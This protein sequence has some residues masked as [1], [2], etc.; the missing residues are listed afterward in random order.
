[1]SFT[2]LFSLF[3]RMSLILIKCVNMYTYVYT[4][5][6]PICIFGA[7]CHLVEVVMVDDDQ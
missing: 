4:K 6:A 3:S 1:M 2:L 5:D 7:A